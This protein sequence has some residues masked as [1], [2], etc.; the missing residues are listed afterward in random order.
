MLRIRIEEWCNVHG[1][2]KMDNIAERKNKKGERVWHR[3][4]WEHVDDMHNLIYNDEEYY[5]TKD[6]FRELNKMWKGYELDERNKDDSS[7]WDDEI[8][9]DW[10][11]VGSDP[12]MNV[13]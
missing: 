12:L 3:S 6:T 8:L 4:D 2:D 7:N 11:N 13:K 5:Y 1:Y 9:N 10:T